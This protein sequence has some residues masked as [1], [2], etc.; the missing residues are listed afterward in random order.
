[1]QYK[2]L[3]RVY[4]AN[5]LIGKWQTTKN[6]TCPTC[7]QKSKHYSQPF[8]LLRHATFGH[9]LN[10]NCLLWHSMSKQFATRRYYFNFDK[11]KQ[12]NK[13]DM[14][15]HAILHAEYYI[16]KQFVASKTM[17]AEVFIDS[18]KHIERQRSIEKN[19]LHI[20]HNRFGKSNLLQ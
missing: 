11:C 19:Q 20:F 17:N 16:H 13:Y 7:K 1:M 10:R 2:I 4:A 9:N 15:N 18:Y 8:Q 14:P 6:E 5:N 3:H 12:V